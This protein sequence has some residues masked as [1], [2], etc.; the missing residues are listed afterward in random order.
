V[1]YLYGSTCRVKLE[2]IEIKKTYTELTEGSLEHFSKKETGFEIVCVVSSSFYCCHHNCLTEKWPTYSMKK[3]SFSLY[4][5][6]GLSGI[7]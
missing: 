7:A 2:T 6:G 5:N 1:C 3:Y 4:G